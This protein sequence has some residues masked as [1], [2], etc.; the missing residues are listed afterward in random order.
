MGACDANG[1]DSGGCCGPTGCDPAP[2]APAR[3]A[4]R[5]APE[6]NGAS[7]VA[8]PTTPQ[9]TQRLRRVQDAPLDG[10]VVL[11]RV[12]HNCV[13]GGRMTDAFRVDSTI[14]TLY[15]IVE[16]GGRPI[17]MTHVGRPYDKKSRAIAVHEDDAVTP[18]V[19][20]LQHKLGVVFAVP[21]FRVDATKGIVDIDTSVN[22]LIQD[23]RARRIGGI[24]LPNTRWFLGEEGLAAGDCGARAARD[25]FATQLAGL[26]DVFVNDAFGSWQPHSSTLGISRL[27]PS[28]AGLLM[29]KEVAALGALIHPRRPF[30]AVIAGS[31]LDTK[32]GTIR[33]VAGR[34]DHVMLGGQLYN[35]YIAAKYGVSIAGVA[36]ED[37]A[38][39]REELFVPEVESKLV[40]LSTVVESETIDG[41]G[42]VPSGG[43]CGTL[44]EAPGA[45]KRFGP[46]RP[47]RV[48]ELKAG[49]SVGYFLDVAAESF[50]E[51]AV[52]A[53]VSNA[54][55][56]FVNA[57]MGLTPS[58]FHEGTEALDAT[59]AANADARKFFGGGDTLH[60]FKSLSPGLYMSA[61]EDPK[62]YLFTGGGTVLK[63]LE[64]G[65]A[66][67]LGTV[68]AL[69]GEDGGETVAGVGAKPK[70]M[71]LSSCDCGPT[72][73]MLHP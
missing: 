7:D 48:A 47:R 28:Y 34:A 63:A 44:S 5:S 55:T 31:K 57:V 24:Y 38:L 14:A 29:Q 36:P 71:Q 73:P 3:P 27:I 61:L 40:H 10:K 33:A 19:R 59:I 6:H 11:V 9:T 42:C 20:Y 68:A 8:V 15:N 30:L 72:D 21:D 52:R 64:M 70:C 4:A 23:L 51:D 12:D 2:G 43:E 60:E 45:G 13:K 37:V 54:A 39:A 35:A 17:L 53:V 67:G 41:C 50:A 18:V 66:E 56:I 49:E 62:Y 32:I 1:S 26:A 65:G 69:M 22:W 25:R 58:G 16:R 46:V